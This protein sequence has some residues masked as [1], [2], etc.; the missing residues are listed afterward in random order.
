MINSSVVF[1]TSVKANCNII[2]SMFKEGSFEP[3]WLYSLQTPMEI[4][5]GVTRDLREI[6]I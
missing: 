2:L 6:V 4:M 3:S 5:K 1:N